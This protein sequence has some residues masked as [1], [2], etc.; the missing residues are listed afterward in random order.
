MRI[1]YAIQ[2]TGNGHLSR[3]RS[4]VPELCRYGIVDVLV[5]GVQVELT[6]DYPVKY[7]F[8]GLGF[9]F[10]K[11]GGIDMLATY[12]KAKLKRFRREIQSLP[13]MDYDL[14][15]S[16][17]EPVSAW[18]CLQRGVPCY[19][20]SHQAAVLS[21][22]APRPK[23]RDGVG[24]AFLQYYA[25][26][27]K[28]YG[29]HFKPYDEGIFTPVIRDGVRRLKPHAGDHYTVYLP[30]YS[31][32]RIIDM[33]LHFPETQWEVFSKNTSG[34]TEHQNII[35]RPL[36]D[37]LFLQSM[38]NSKGVLCGA[39]FETPAEALFLGKKLLVI[40]MKGQYEQQC[41]AAALKK[42]GVP[43]IRNLKEQQVSAIDAW[44]DDRTVVPVDYPDQ[45]AEI[46]RQLVDEAVAAK[47]DAQ[48]QQLPPKKFRKSLFQKAVAA[49]INA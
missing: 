23:K 11:K 34:L 38:A 44:L 30:A 43:V 4:I 1:L 8:Q 20:L 31:D 37:N 24:T 33:L 13:V 42:L 35:I 47:R 45:T 16:D 6:L 29:F 22:H 14:V 18:A 36:H 40:P 10:G 17:F 19:G 27:T 3:A 32:A 2:G 46:V 5:S 12:R 7:R 39:G 21:E 48:D 41:N 28:A 9:I 15:I 26:V 25:P 49:Y